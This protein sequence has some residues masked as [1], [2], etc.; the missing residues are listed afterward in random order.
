MAVEKSTKEVLLRVDR[1]T[2]DVFR[3]VVHAGHEVNE[4]PETRFTTEE[5]A[6][7]IINRLVSQGFLKKH[8]VDAL[9]GSVRKRIRLR[10]LRKKK[11]VRRQEE[12][13]LAIARQNRARRVS[14]YHLPSVISSFFGL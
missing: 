7:E 1:V 13:R 12:I 3:F 8:Y 6:I 11:K 4:I 5:K 9:K 14:K 2:E 10:D